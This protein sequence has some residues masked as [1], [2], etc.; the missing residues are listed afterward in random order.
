MIMKIIITSILLFTIVLTISGFV[1]KADDLLASANSAI[2]LTNLHQFKK[3][4]E[5][6]YID[7]GNYPIVNGSGELFDLLKNKKYIKENIPI[8]YNNFDYQVKDNGQ[9]Y[10]LEIN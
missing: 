4:I 2:N 10:S 8:N 1:V 6:Y 7:N 3:A 9:N 5:I